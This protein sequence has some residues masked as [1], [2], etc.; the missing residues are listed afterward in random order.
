MNTT[1]MNSVNWHPRWS[2]VMC[3]GLMVFMIFGVSL[4][5]GCSITF[6]GRIVNP[7][8]LPDVDCPTGTARLANTSKKTT[9]T[10]MLDA[11]SDAPDVDCPTGM[12]RL[13]NASKKTTDTCM[14]DTDGDGTPD[15][16][17]LMG[18]IRLAG[19]SIN[20]MDTCVPDDDGDGIPDSM[21]VDADGDGL[22]EIK[23][24]EMLD[25]MR[26]DLA[27]T[28]YKTSA[29]QTTGNTDGCPAVGSGGCN[30]YELTADIDLLS[31]LDANGNGMID[32]TMEGIDKNADGDTTDAG[33]QI[34]VIDTTADTSWMPI[35]D[36]STNDDITRFTGTFEGNNHTIAN[37]WVN[38]SSSDNAHAG[39]FGVTGGTTVTIR[40]VSV[41]SGS[42]HSSATSASGQSNA[43][44]LVGLS[45][46]SLIISDCTFSGSLGVSTSNNAGGLVGASGAPLIISNCTFLGSGDISSSN[47]S[48]SS[49]GGLVGW[50][51]SSLTI[52]NSIFSGSGDIS[53]SASN[54]STHS[55]GLVGWM[56]SSLTI[57][58]CI[59]SGS[60]DISASSPSASNS[61]IVGGLTG[62]AYSTSPVSWTI[63][64]CSFFG[65]GQISSM[66]TNSFTVGGLI[67]TTN[68]S[69]TIRNSYWNKD[70]I[71][72][73]GGS[74]Q[75]PKRA[76]GDASSDPSGTIGLTL[77]ELQAITGIH[78]SGLP[79]S[80]TDSTKAWDL[81]TASQLPA[82]KLCIPTI[83]SGVTDWTMCASYGALLAGQ[84]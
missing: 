59:F 22:I 68:S 17:C 12:A 41:I 75:S 66:G 51:S 65:S 35:G 38:I 9:D 36:N 74:N 11:D 28:S 52:T 60:G 27:G 76:K 19:T 40:N 44:G 30:G 49:A 6:P 20:T 64:N 55:G 8:P 73:V 14:P 48:G 56:S 13:A 3:V 72:R 62:H 4:S 83:T 78:P 63:T 53:A 25:N 77:V 31:L 82:I 71:Q 69:L 1:L 61:S 16:T 34:T 81:G 2:L 47:Q 18:T 7:P 37:L 54:G 80:A 50:I 32:T 5:T 39:L 79:H 33:E 45:T 29:T 26:Y 24:A 15:V 42:I 84:R 70:A 46:A 10:C 67:G 58:N 23:T 21:D 43:G 57:T